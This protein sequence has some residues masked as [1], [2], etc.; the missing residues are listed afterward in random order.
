[1]VF[2]SRR[3]GERNRL[4]DRRPAE[5]PVN[6]NWTFADRRYTTTKS[7]WVQIS[8]FFLISLVGL[9][10][11]T[12]VREIVSHLLYPFWQTVFHNPMMAEVINYNFSIAA[13]GV[14]LF[15]NFILNRIWTFRQPVARLW[16]WHGYCRHRLYSG[17]PPAGGHWPHHT[18]AG[19]CAGSLRVLGWTCGCLSSG[20]QIKASEAPLPLHTT[21]ADERNMVR[22]CTG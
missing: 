4:Y 16:S 8:Q 15:W 22:L 14:V 3:H 12:I 5:L 20:E 17:D 18:R 1:M 13:I 11:N 9:G 7:R 19:C 10:I 6:Y 2:I 21:P